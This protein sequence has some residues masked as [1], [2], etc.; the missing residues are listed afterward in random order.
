MLSSNYWRKY[1]ED[2]ETTLAPFDSDD[3]DSDI[4]DDDSTIIFEHDEDY[5][6]DRLFYRNMFTDFTNLAA[7]G[8]SNIP[9]MVRE[10]LACHN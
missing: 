1:G 5:A 6:Y 4:S 3:D 8:I 9:G 2:D 10:T 7:R